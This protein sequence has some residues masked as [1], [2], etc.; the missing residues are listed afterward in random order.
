MKCARCGEDIT[1]PYIFEGKAFGYT[2]I[3]IVN[4]LA[5]KA[6][7]NKAHWVKA[8]RFELPEDNK[9]IAFYQGANY[10]VGK[11]VDYHHYVKTLSGNLMAVSPINIFVQ[12]NEAYINLK[13]YK[14]GINYIPTQSY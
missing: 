3:K 14:S 6:A 9:I 5:K 8:D 4:P 2:C 1:A 10:K 7:K 11:F 13:G 12:G